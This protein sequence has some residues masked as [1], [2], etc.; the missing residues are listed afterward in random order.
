ME[1]RALYHPLQTD[2]NQIIKAWKLYFEELRPQPEA[3]DW[4]HG[5][6]ALEKSSQQK[7]TLIIFSKGWTCK[8]G[9]LRAEKYIFNSAE[10]SYPPQQTIL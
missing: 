7:A 8:F 1:L 9:K 6:F 3:I 10:K 5:I 4:F 2:L